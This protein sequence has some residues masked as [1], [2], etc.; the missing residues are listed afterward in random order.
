M[1][2]SNSVSRGFSP[3]ASRLE[4]A[5]AQALPGRQAHPTRNPVGPRFHGSHRLELRRS[6]VSD[7]P[8]DRGLVDAG[9]SRAVFLCRPNCCEEAL[10]VHDARIMPR[11]IMTVN[12][13]ALGAVS[14]YAPMIVR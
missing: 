5:P 2:L 3:S 1:M 7:E 13:A 12:P 8:A 14:L 9:A 4:I 6:F 10:Q 11:C